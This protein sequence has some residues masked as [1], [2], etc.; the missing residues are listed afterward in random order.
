[1][2][3]CC[4]SPVTQ[5]PDCFPSVAACVPVQ[6]APKCRHLGITNQAAHCKTQLDAWNACS[7]SLLRLALGP[8]QIL[9]IAAETCT[10]A[11]GS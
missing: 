3:K 7:A 11:S 10:S 9:G 6:P 2:A 4:K 5:L 1:M 8:K